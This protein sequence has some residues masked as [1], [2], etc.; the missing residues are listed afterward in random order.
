MFDGGVCVV[1]FE[2]VFELHERVAV[3]LFDEMKMWD[4]C[5]HSH[6]LDHCSVESPERNYLIFKAGGD[7][8]SSYK[9]IVRRS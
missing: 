3:N 8:V 7:R 6:C 2:E 1:L 9:R 4:F 5:G